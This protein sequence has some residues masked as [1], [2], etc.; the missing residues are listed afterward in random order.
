MK[1][2]RLRSYIAPGAPATRAPCDGTEPDLRVEFGF[3]PRWFHERCGVDFSERW[4]LDPIYRRESLVTMRRELNRRFPSLELGGPEPDACPFAPSAG[5][6]FHRFR[7]QFVPPVRAR[8]GYRMIA[9]FSSF[10]V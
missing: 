6:E 10:P 4:H 7:S 3:T 5:E 1:L 2:H 9:H 8:Q